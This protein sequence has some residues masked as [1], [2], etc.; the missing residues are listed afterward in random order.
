MNSQTEEQ[1]EL[2]TVY[3]AAGLLQGQVVKGYLEDAGIPVLLA[4]E[5]VGPIIGVTVDGIGQVR[6][7]VPKE[8]EQEARALLEE[9]RDAETNSDQSP[10]D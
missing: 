8:H 6:V 5:S 3:T 4:Y 10:G 2:V 7:Q 9:R 1:F